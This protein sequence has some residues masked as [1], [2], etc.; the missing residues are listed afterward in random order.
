MFKNLILI[1]IT[2]ESIVELPRHLFTSIDLVVL[3]LSCYCFCSSHLTVF[4]PR[5]KVLHLCPLEFLDDGSLKNLLSGCPV[6]EELEIYTSLGDKINTLCICSSTIKKLIVNNNLKERSVQCGV[7]IKAPSLESLKLSD[8]VSRDFEVDELPALVKADVR[9][10]FTSDD[11]E[12]SDYYCNAVVRLLAK[13]SNVKHLW[14]ANT[15]L[16][17][18]IHASAYN[19]LLFHS[20]TH[21]HLDIHDIPW[22][23]VPD[24]LGHI[25]SLTVLVLNK[26]R[27]GCDVCLWCG[28]PEN[29][30]ICL[31]LRL[32]KMEFNGFSG[33]NKEMKLVWYLLENAM[34]LKKLTLRSWSRNKKI[35]TDLQ[36]YKRGSS[37]CQIKFCHQKGIF[38]FRHQL[39]SSEWL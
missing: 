16:K 31:S 20:L 5:L 24:L 15:T 32:E 39:S 37:T 29:V 28:A 18:V 10:C 19:E 3:K 26:N 9:V 8:S 2:T 6:L 36:K 22:S 33:C 1:S 11:Y 38:G 12:G 25:P 14:L 34:V 7:V 23:V 35:K 17:V 4:L 30:P 21:L 13:A 27:K